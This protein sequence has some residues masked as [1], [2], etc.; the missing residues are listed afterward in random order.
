MRPMSNISLTEKLLTAVSSFTVSSFTVF[1]FTELAPPPPRAV[2]FLRRAAVLSATAA[3]T[4]LPA[5]AAIFTV[6]SNGECTHETLQD[7]IQAAYNN[8]SPVPTVDE[9][10][11]SEREG[12]EEGAIPFVGEYEIFDQ[13][14]S[15]RGGFEN[16]DSTSRSGQTQ[17]DRPEGARHFTIYSSGAD[18]RVTLEGLNL[19]TTGGPAEIGEGGSIHLSGRSHLTVRDS[20]V[21]QGV[22][23]IGGGIFID[24][25]DGAYLNLDD[26]AVV[27]QNEAQIGGGIFCS[28]EGGVWLSKTALVL[29][30]TADSAGGGLY[31]DGCSLY[32]DRQTPWTGIIRN[33]ADEG[34]GIY[35]TGGSRAEVRGNLLEN[36]ANRGGAAL[37]EVEGSQLILN[38]G[39]TASNVAL[40]QG[41][42]VYARRQGFVSMFYRDEECVDLSVCNAMVDNRATHDGGAFYGESGAQIFITGARLADNGSRYGAVAVIDGSTSYLDM[43]STEVVGNVG[44]IMV[45]VTGG[46]VFRGSYLTL[47]DNKPHL[48][49]SG[50]LWAFNNRPSNSEV[51]NTILWDEDGR[52][53][54]ASSSPVGAYTCLLIPTMFHDP[55]SPTAVVGDPRFVDEAARDFSLGPNSEAVDLCP[56]TLSSNPDRAFQ[57]RVRN[58]GSEP[59]IHGPADAGA[60]ERQP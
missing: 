17:I 18:T 52:F 49:T 29:K 40:G 34:G 32:V 13:V 21:G 15:I 14:V 41:A 33:V 1:S 31:L 59:D 20:H 2:R 36:V 57:D 4:A 43:E 26:M 44:D 53:H 10:R 12:E 47:G 50:D 3:L 16:C 42:G 39:L 7:A 30:N 8:E 9:I 24:G 60:F 51:R 23:E 22:A 28:G 5:S 19:V 58:D 35:A 46:A 48:V 54:L 56:A 25:E 6:G 27:W 45:Q 38:G 55:G 37:V 11:L